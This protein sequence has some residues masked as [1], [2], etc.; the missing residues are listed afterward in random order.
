MRAASILTLLLLSCSDSPNGAP[1]DG[2]GEGL[3]FHDGLG[4]DGTAP[5]PDRSPLKPDTT[6]SP[7]DWDGDG[8]SNDEEKKLG[9]DPKNRDTDGDGLD[10]K[11]EV[12]DVASPKDADGDKRPDALE[13]SDFDSDKDGKPDDQ[14][15]DDSDGPCGKTPRLMVLLTLTQSR[16]LTKACSPYRVQGHVW[17]TGGSTLAA[18]PGVTVELGPGAAILLGDATGKGSLKLAGTAA[19]KVKLTSEA[20]PAKKGTW[21]GIAAE[22]AETLELLHTQLE[23]A[24]APTGSGDPEAAIYVKSAASIT[25]SGLAVSQSSGHGLHAAFS[26]SPG[27][28][29]VAFEESSLAADV[30]AALHIRHVTEIGKGMSFGTPGAGGVVEVVSGT[31]D[32]PAVWKSIG[33]P[34][35]LLEATLTLEASLTLEAGVNLEVPSG[36]AIDVGYTSTDAAIHAAGTALKPITIGTASGA[37]GSWNGILVYQGSSTFSSTTIAGAG[38]T[39]SQG[40]EAGLYIDKS[41]TVLATQATLKESTGYGVYVYRESNGCQGLSTSGYSFSGSFTGSTSFP[42]CKLFCLDDA[43]SPGACLVK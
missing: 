42:G 30:G 32:K 9:T 35:R 33:V 19:E 39:S 5:T 38:H 17:M 8:L 1:S 3:A 6:A 10:D 25:I 28:L 12:G 18:E 7:T 13:P 21:R 15:G 36:A 31:L 20:Q 2:G 26:V 24:G 34:Y 43:N 22:N 14:D 27:P 23:G 40:V 16:T 37:A 11:A 29:F 41:A 4:V